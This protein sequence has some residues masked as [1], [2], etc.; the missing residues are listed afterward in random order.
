MSDFERI[1]DLVFRSL[2]GPLTDAEQQELAAWIAVSDRNREWYERIQGEEY[3]RQSFL[4][5]RGDQAE[6]SKA[7]V[8]DR[9]EGALVTG[10]RVH[11]LRTAWFKYAAAIIILF[12]I[13]A[14][15]WNKQNN[16]SITTQQVAV[17]KDILPGG[18]KA[19]LTLADGRK[20]IL[21]SVKNG[22][23]AQQGGTSIYKSQDGLV[24]YEKNDL[25]ST[26]KHL[27]EYN[28]IS[29]PRGG[30]YKIV[31]SDGT[32]VWLNAVSSITFPT[33]F[34]D[35][36]R[37]VSI[38]GEAYF[39]VAKNA[40]APFKVIINN[41]AEVEVLGTHFNVN[42]Y[43]DETAI[44]TTLLEGRVRV[45]NL[46][47]T[48]SRTTLAPGTQAA[49]FRNSGKPNIIEVKAA[50]IDQVMA[51]RNGK[52]NFQ[53]KELKEAMKELV[54]WYEIE[55][56]Y[57]KDVP[58]IVFEGKMDRRLKLSQVLNGLQDMGVEFKLIENRRLI[59][60][61]EK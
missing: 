43:E 48:Q 21:D 17:E 13:G 41:E 51:W 9:I 7:R 56:V 16:S 55:I 61:P 22:Q 12:G 36:A 18:Q 33:T 35:S 24:S 14:Y 2:S 60:G 23:L 44:R 47:Q 10:K 32:I 26:P 57:E 58:R 27:T 46:H 39:E 29:T 45:I 50:N 19:I 4:S 34:G 6:V 20:I 42:A 28:T 49:I 1:A 15:L 54:R 40:H 52:F 30:E 11:I 31:L 38:S 59:I 37:R 5:F 8:L 53:G 3:L 25:P